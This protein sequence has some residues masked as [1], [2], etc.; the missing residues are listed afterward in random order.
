[1]SEHVTDSSFADDADSDGEILLPLPPERIQELYEIMVVLREKRPHFIQ[2]YLANAS[3]TV[4]EYAS[5]LLDGATVPS[6]RLQRAIVEALRRHDPAID[7]E[8][9]LVELQKGVLFDSSG[10]CGLIGDSQSLHSLLLLALGAR[11]RGDSRIYALAGGGVPL[12]NITLP[13]GYYWDG[14]R[15]NLFPTKING[16]SSGAMTA[17]TV[18]ACTRQNVLRLPE[19]YKGELDANGFPTDLGVLSAERRPFASFVQREAARPE[20]PLQYVFTTPELRFCDQVARFNEVLWH[21]LGETPNGLPDLA[22]MLIE[23]VTCAVLDELIVNESAST[24]ESRDPLYR[25]LFDADLRNRVVDAFNV[26]DPGAPVVQGAWRHDENRAVSYGTH[27]FWLLEGT[28][29]TDNVTG[30]MSVKNARMSSLSLTESGTLFNAAGTFSMEMSPQNVRE[31]LNGMIREDGK[32]VKLA[33]GTFLNIVI[34]TLEG[35]SILGGMNQSE[36]ASTYQRILAPIL[37]E[38]VP[39][40]AVETFKQLPLSNFCFGLFF[41]N[42]EGKAGAFE[43]LLLRPDVLVESVNQHATTMTVAEAGV[44]AV[45]D[46]VSIVVPKSEFQEKLAGKLIEVALPDGNTTYKLAPRFSFESLYR[47]MRTAEAEQRVASSE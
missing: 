5:M 23:D 38:H 41:T 7:E 36:Y 40:K 8:S 33:P 19:K 31:L 45:N 1:M 18:Q 25:L 16:E 17:S 39:C 35:G 37:S 4:E 21:G 20:S 27:L 46:C 42:I 11:H 32:A 22:Y 14:N 24:Q 9:I 2:S 13:G 29:Y 10:H 12:N 47:E 26:P 34:T 44:L 15:V 28:P 30:R 3:K 6:D 43:H